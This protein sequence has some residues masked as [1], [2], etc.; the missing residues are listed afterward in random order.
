[1]QMFEGQRTSIFP[2]KVPFKM[3]DRRKKNSLGHGEWQG[4]VLE[5]NKVDE[6]RIPYPDACAI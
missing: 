6:G 1:M 5:R 3:I 2:V 4:Q